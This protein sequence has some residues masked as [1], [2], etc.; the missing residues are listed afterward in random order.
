MI[1]SFGWS[2]CGC[3]ASFFALLRPALTSVKGAA[4]FLSLRFQNNANSRLPV[5]SERTGRGIKIFVGG[6]RR[7]VASPEKA[8]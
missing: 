8:R 2:S 4:S 7:A 5:A 6:A 1:V 3:G